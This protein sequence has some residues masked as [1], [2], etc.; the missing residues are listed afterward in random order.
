[1]RA[2]HYLGVGPWEL[3]EHLVWR[4]RALAVESAENEAQKRLADKK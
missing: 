3:G 1:V 2:A 4:D